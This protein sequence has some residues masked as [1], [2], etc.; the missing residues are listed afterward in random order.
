MARHLHIEPFNGIAGDM[1]LAALVDL[2]A[3]LEP[4]QQ[5]LSATGFPGIDRVALTAVP[6]EELGVS[7]L[8]LEIAVTP[9][10]GPAPQPYGTLVDA[11]DRVA[12]PER[13]R[14]RAR[15]A[16]DAVARAKTRAGAGGPAEQV[17]DELGGFDSVIDFA[18]VTLALEGLGVDSVTCAPLPF[19]TGPIRRGAVALPSPTRAV[20]ELVHGLPAVG[21]DLAGELLTATGV[22]LARTLADRF[23]EPP[24]MVLGAVGVGFGRSRFPGRPN[25][26]RLHLGERATHEPAR[27]DLA[28][29]EANLDDLSPELLAPLIETCLAA[30]ALDAWLAPILMKKGRPGQLLSVL[31]PPERV[32]AVEETVFRH[33]TTL[34]VRRRVVERRALERRWEDAATPWGPVRIKVGLLG[35][36]VV[37]RAPEFE[38]CRRVAEAAGVPVKEVYAA[39]LAA[40]VPR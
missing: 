15:A 25:C 22:A 14:A 7:G 26:L 29:L 34:G 16:L 17:F 28:V 4:I 40:A 20:L 37:N 23:G 11:L 13:A 31:C 2:G 30:G 32:A 9:P 36:E 21:V 1:L 18:G 12:L 38:D 35:T 27:A 33:S 3:P 10:A 6:V 8:R 24:P 39:A 19:A 5:A